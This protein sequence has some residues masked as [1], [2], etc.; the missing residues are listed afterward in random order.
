MFKEGGLHRRR[1]GTGVVG[2]AIALATALALTA[3]PATAAT[4]PATATATAAAP[5]AATAATPP[6]AATATPP[7]P[8]SAADQVRQLIATKARTCPHFTIESVDAE[9]TTSDEE[10]DTRPAGYDVT[11]QLSK[12]AGGPAE[13]LVTSNHDAV[14]P[15][16]AVAGALELGC[17]RDPATPKSPLGWHA[18]PY[19]DLD[20]GAIQAGSDGPWRGATT[21]RFLP[22]F[23]ATFPEG[24]GAPVWAKTCERGSQVVSF[25]RTLN[26]LGPPDSLSFLL[27]AAVKGNGARPL[28][29]VELIVNGR[30]VY[31][32]AAGG[33]YAA[34]Q[35]D[36]AALSSVRF[37][38]NGFEVVVAKPASAACNTRNAA[39]QYGVHFTIAGHF[40][41]DAGGES[42]AP[43]G[44]ISCGKSTCTGQA[45]F[46]FTFTN[47][48]P[49]ELLEPQVSVTLT[50]GAA[51]E[52]DYSSFSATENGLSGV[53]CRS[54]HPL[55][56]KYRLFCDWQPTPPAGT[57]SLAFKFSFHI[58]RPH[59]TKAVAQT[60]TL[61][62]SFPGAYGTGA[63]N[64]GGTRSAFICGPVGPGC[65]TPIAYESAKD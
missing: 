58:A 45:S 29:W 40:H 42:V 15:D 39:A 8:T 53:R 48:G 31:R 6:A 9:P 16:N 23:S 19:A 50:T 62:W 20:A 36:H 41:A 1:L 37:G 26:L 33:N 59:A 14:V 11:V 49:S 28:R 34:G 27:T 60:W 47:E 52:L 18:L 2:A 63:L 12:P 17:R 3:P 24:N 55:N 51:N 4:R 10:T 25:E 7:T 13:F 65:E 57:G 44:T 46:P 64:A 5:P 54:S 61:T 22:T 43:T 32:S 38:A 35:L 21:N 30:T 56:T